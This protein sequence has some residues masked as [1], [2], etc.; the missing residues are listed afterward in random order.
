MFIVSN[1]VSCPICPRPKI[2]VN[3]GISLASLP[4]SS[5]ARLSLMT[6]NWLES[7]WQLNKISSS[8]PLYQWAFGRLSRIKAR[9]EQSL[10]ETDVSVVRVPPLFA[11]ADYH[12][13]VER[14]DRS[15][16]FRNPIHVDVRNI[17]VDASCPYDRGCTRNWFSSKR[18]HP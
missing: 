10:S 7:C 4:R 16:N 13:L 12:S 6:Y 11:D 14:R 8:S 18:I 2:K 17:L 3:Q 9:R 1:I 5:S 15:K